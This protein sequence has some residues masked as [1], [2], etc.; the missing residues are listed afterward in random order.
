VLRVAAERHDIQYCEPAD[1]RVHQKFNY[2]LKP[3][4][5]GRFPLDARQGRAYVFGNLS[6]QG[7]EIRPAS[8]RRGGAG[9]RPA[10]HGD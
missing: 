1:Y 3:L 8:I 7:G 6:L 2:G 10:S 5:S 9:R 4:P